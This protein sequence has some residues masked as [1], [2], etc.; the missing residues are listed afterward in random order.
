[1]AA[2][3][4]QR[5]LVAAAALNQVNMVKSTNYES[6]IFSVAFMSNFINY[7][8]QSLTVDSRVYKSSLGQAM[9]EPH[10]HF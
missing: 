9:F 10:P 3:I 8:N 6:A 5:L 4:L 2:V 1:M 7:H